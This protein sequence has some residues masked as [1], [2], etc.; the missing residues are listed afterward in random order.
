MK[1]KDSKKIYPEYEKFIFINP[2]ALHSWYEA[3]NS[4]FRHDLIK[5]SQYLL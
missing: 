3:K 2:L 4:K 5:I 1:S